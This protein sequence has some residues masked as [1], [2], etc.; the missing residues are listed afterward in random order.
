V[1]G[2]TA[3]RNSAVINYVPGT[4]FSCSKCFWGRQNSR[5]ISRGYCIAYKTNAD[6]VWVRKIKDFHNCTC[7]RY[8]YGTPKVVSSMMGHCRGCRVCTCP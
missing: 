2:T 4:P 8:E 1:E 6:T 3:L 7:G 5:D